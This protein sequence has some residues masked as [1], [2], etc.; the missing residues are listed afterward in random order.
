MGSLKARQALSL[1]SQ[2]LPYIPTRAVMAAVPSTHTPAPTVSSAAPVRAPATKATPTSPAPLPTTSASL[3][4]VL[5]LA[6]FLFF[7]ASGRHLVSS[8][9]VPE[10]NRAA[11]STAASPIV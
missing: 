3:D 6:S 11:I 9:N 5:G 2:G 10:D 4:F 8:R 7:N 1:A